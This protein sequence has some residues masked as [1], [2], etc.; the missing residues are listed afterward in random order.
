MGFGRRRSRGLIFAREEL[1]SRASFQR[2]LAR[3]AMKAPPATAA[4]YRPEPPGSL[5]LAELRDRAKKCRACPL[6]R[7]GTQTVFGAGPPSARVVFVGEQPGDQEDRAGEPFVG[8]AGRLL[9]EALTAAKIERRLVYVTNAV[10]HFKWKPAGK[11]RMHVSLQ[12]SFVI[13]REAKPTAAI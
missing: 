11:R 12:T 8:P 2:F 9:D 3:R 6:Y 7:L 10:K 13:A 5:A 4:R 1:P